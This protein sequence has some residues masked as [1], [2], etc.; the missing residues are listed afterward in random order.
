MDHGPDSE[1]SRYVTAARPELRRRAFLLCG[2]W[3][4]ADDLVQQTLIKVFLHWDSLDR[5]DE[6]SAYAGTVM[7]RSFLNGR[8]AFGRSREFPTGQ[9]PEP[10][11]EPEDQQRLL[12]QLLLVDALARLGPRQRAVI[13]LRYWECLTVGEAA[14]ALSCSA[15]TIRSQTFRALTNL[16]SLLQHDLHLPEGGSQDQI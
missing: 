3:H 16:R 4:E 7:L 6:L 13:V 9:V 1:F 8:R 15:A 12:D 5:R 2:Q 11:P 14:D 10:D